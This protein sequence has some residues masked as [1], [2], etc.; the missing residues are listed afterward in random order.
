MKHFKAPKEHLGALSAEA[1]ASLIAA[2]GDVAMILDADGI[3]RDFAFQSDEMPKMLAAQKK[4]LGKHW[5]KVVTAESRL[6]IEALL[7]EAKPERPTAWRHVNHP[8]PDGTDLPVLYSVVQAGKAGGFVALGRDLRPMAVLQQQVVQAQE[9]MER[10][11]SRLRHI[12][13]RYRLLFELSAEAVLIVEASSLRVIDANPAAR[14]LLGDAAKK[15][16]AG[17][18]VFQ[19]FTEDSA[20]SVRSLLEAVR[21]GG[22]A[23]N[24]EARLLRP[25]QDVV[26]SAS[27]FRQDSETLFL[28]RLSNK[29]PADA[30]AFPKLKS[31]MLKIVENAP[32]GFVMTGP[33]G[34]ILTANAAFIDMVNAKSEEEV[35][36]QR[37]ERWVG[38]PGV[39]ADILISNL[40]QRGSV[41]LFGTTLNVEYGPSSQV[42]ISAVSVMNGG[43]P[44]FGF[45]LR[46]IGQRL[47]GETRSGRQL[48]RSPEQLTELIGRMSL[49]DLVRETTDVIER[50][51]IEAALELT[52]DNRASA[53][54][55]LGLSRQSLYVKLRRYG[56]ADDTTNP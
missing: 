51:C 56:L 24:V 46:G 26:V 43:T 40:R 31:K 12:E 18:S 49:K 14:S 33:D 22:R 13:M 27:L 15:L 53:A 9:T 47:S 39:D 25:D 16:A 37:L 17:R 36:G 7:R 32:D 21:A 6:K 2:A 41:R 38:R 1:A 34:V 30:A 5:S 29:S 54:E 44:C 55:L 3:I 11:Y 23:D 50:L 52:S 28:V 8:L 4:W 42:E 35:R 20:H 10:D 48:P 19:A 45:T